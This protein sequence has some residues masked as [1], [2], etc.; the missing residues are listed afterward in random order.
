M[1]VAAA[2]WVRARAAADSCL[3]STS[4]RSSFAKRVLGPN[5]GRIGAVGWRQQVAELGAQLLAFIT[6]F[7]FPAVQYLLLKRYARREGEARLWYLPAYGF[8]LVMSNID[9]KSTFSEIRYRTFIRDAVPAGPGSSVKTW[10]DELLL[11]RDDFFL[12]P[13]GD[14]LLATFRLEC[15]AAGDLVLVGTDKLGKELSR[16]PIPKGAA[17]I[18]DYSATLENFF[19]FDIRVARRVEFGYE[20]LHE[21]CTEVL[22]SPHEEVSFEPSRIR[23]VG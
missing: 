4:L 5:L 1:S 20:R 13:G 21:A 19:N 3:C 22:A 10:R 7:A 12:F 9:R 16:H 23:P 14:Q 2:G 6:F 15:L 17:L 11:E 8:R 18:A